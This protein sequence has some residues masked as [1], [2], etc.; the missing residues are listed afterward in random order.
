MFRWHFSH[1][2]IPAR[3]WVR[4]EL[5][6]LINAVIAK[7]SLF[8]SRYN[9]DFGY[10]V[11]GHLQAMGS[12]SWLHPF[13]EL[14]AFYYAAHPPLGFLLANTASAIT[15]TPPIV[16]AQ[17]VSILSS[18]AILFFLRATLK[19]LGLLHQPSAIAFLY[20]VTGLPLVTFMQIGVNLD[21]II[22]A[23]VCVMLYFSTIL[24]YTESKS[25]LGWVTV[26]AGLTAA[27][28]CLTKE[29]GFLL[30]AIPTLCFCFVRTNLLLQMKRFLVIVGVAS[31]L[32]FPYYFVN[33]YIPEK[34]FF[35]GNAGQTAFVDGYNITKT[36]QKE[37]YFAFAKSLISAYPQGE[38]RLASTWRSFWQ[39][40]GLYPKSELAFPIIKFYL[41]ITPFLILSGLLIFVRKYSPGSKWHSFGMV[42]VGFSLLQILF[43]VVLITMYP[44]D[45]FAFNKGIYIA[46]AALGIC[47]FLSLLAEIPDLLFRRSPQLCGLLQICCIVAVTVF[48]IVNHAVPVY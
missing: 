27:A 24:A 15:G 19:R 46:P 43:T 26:C 40:E 21:I 47:F 13:F 23:L 7:F 3:T 37:D 35:F 22:F 45:G 33:Y 12:V 18:L 34:T 42:L 17:I 48:F 8:Y 2:K 10:D 9:V 6:M 16:G 36:R 20:L 28:A 32:V 31:S 29:S 39:A 38:A 4:I 14:R 11:G 5:L 44:I 41:M 25:V 30:F 1:P